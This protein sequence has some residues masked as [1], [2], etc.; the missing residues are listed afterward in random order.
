MSEIL[1]REGGKRKEWVCGWDPGMGRYP[2]RSSASIALSLGNSCHV[3][4]S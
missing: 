4:S 1:H 3:S 2:G